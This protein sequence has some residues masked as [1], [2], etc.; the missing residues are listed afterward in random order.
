MHPYLPAPIV[1]HCSCSTC[2][3]SRAR[4]AILSLHCLCAFDGLWR[5]RDQ[6]Q[7][8]DTFRRVAKPVHDVFLSA[9]ISSLRDIE[10]ALPGYRLAFRGLEDFEC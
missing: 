1:S 3:N 6:L 7:A 8:N 4:H 2:D 9:H 10:D 5:Y